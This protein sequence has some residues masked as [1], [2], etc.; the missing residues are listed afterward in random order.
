MKKP[1]GARKGNRNAAKPGRKQYIQVFGQ[2]WTVE[3]GEKIMAYLEQQGE[4]QKQ[5]LCDIVEEKILTEI[6]DA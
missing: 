2:R 1:R 4:T 5:F 6:A 3:T